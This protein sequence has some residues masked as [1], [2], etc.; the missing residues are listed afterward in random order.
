MEYGIMEHMK[1]MQEYKRTSDLENQIEGLQKIIFENQPAWTNDYLG[2]QQ[3]EINALK[4]NNK[5][6]QDKVTH[7]EDLNNVSLI[8]V[9]K[10]KIKNLFKY[11]LNITIEKRSK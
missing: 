2:W 8:S 10:C 11:K 1:K 3:K 6:L 5:T 9:I 7:L 4:E